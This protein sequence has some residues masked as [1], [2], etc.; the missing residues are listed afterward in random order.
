M[1][2]SAKASPIAHESSSASSPS[3]QIKKR[4]HLAL[5]D[6]IPESGPF[7][8]LRDVRVAFPLY[9]EIDD[10]EETSVGGRIVRDR[11][12]RQWVQALNGVS[13]DILPGDRVGIAGHN[14]AGK[15]TLLQVLAGTQMPTNGTLSYRGNISRLLSPNAGMQQHASGYDNIKMRGMLQGMSDDEIENALPEIDAFT[16]LGPYLHLP[17]AQYSGGMRLRLS[18]AIA[19]AMKPDI[20]LID[21]WM[22]AGDRE[23]QAKAKAR[24]DAFTESAS[25]LVIAT[26]NQSLLRTFCNVVYHF[27]KGEIVDVQRISENGS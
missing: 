27:E 17:M 18:F 12:R 11:K 3:K 6:S 7:L 26:H 4:D 16:E 1:S 13:L 9:R 20:L 23:F 14:G 8:Q 15:S 24:F 2:E 21:E 19:T 25:I 10:S 5:T 22:G